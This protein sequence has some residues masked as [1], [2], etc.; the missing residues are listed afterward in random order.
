[1]II[2][3][4][5]IRYILAGLR[6]KCKY[7]PQSWDYVPNQ[8]EFQITYRVCRSKTIFLGHKMYRSVITSR[9][10]VLDLSQELDSELCDIVTLEVVLGKPCCYLKMH[11][12]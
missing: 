7:I 6:V 11:H 10:G 8:Q 5:G 2:C 3:L 12:L 4:F 9:N 1:M